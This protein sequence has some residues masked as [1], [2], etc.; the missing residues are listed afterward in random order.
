MAQ[1]LADHQVRT[2]RAHDDGDGEEVVVAVADGQLKGHQWQE[3]ES[4]KLLE[5]ALRY[6]QGA[7]VHERLQV[8]VEEAD[9]ADE[10]VQE[11]CDPGVPQVEPSEEES[12]RA[13]S[14]DT[15]HQEHLHVYQLQVL[16]G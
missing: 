14:Q 5:H 10:S 3:Q 2:G 7:Q 13:N 15:V 4:P 12:R 11:E 6:L 16:S 1:S 9:D 8:E